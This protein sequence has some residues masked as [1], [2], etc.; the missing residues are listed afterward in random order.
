MGKQ[1]IPGLL[2]GSSTLALG[3]SGGIVG[4]KFRRT[5]AECKIKTKGG[6]RVL[7]KDA[8]RPE[9]DFNYKLFFQMLRPDFWYLIAAVVSALVVAVLNIQIPVYLGDLVQILSESTTSGMS[10][11][12]Y[13][14]Q[15]RQPAVKLLSA[16][17]M[18]AVATCGYISLLSTVG[19]RLAARMREALFASLI[20]QDIAFFDEHGT[21]ELINRLSADVQDFKSAFKLCV[22][23]GLRGTTQAVGSVVSM[24]LLS[25]K[26]TVIMVA[27]VPGIVFGGALIGASLRGLS[28]MVQQQVALAS[29][30]ADEALGNIRTVRAFAM[31]GKEEELY[32]KE[33]EKS[34]TLNEMLGVGIGAFQAISN[35]ALNGIVLGVI[36]SG[37]Y[38]LVT[39]EI[40]AGQLMS[41]LVASQAIQRSLASLSIL[42]GSAVRGMSAG[43]RVF[44]YMCL[45]PSL[46]IHGGISIPYHSLNA[47]V[48]FNGVTFSYPS[49]QEQKVLENFSMSIPKGK[50]M[51]VCGPSGAGKSTVA[52][53]LERFY[54]IQGGSITI[55]GVDIRDLD[56]A[57]LR[58]RCIGFISQ[59]PVLFA[60]SVKEN[61]RYG[62]PDATDQEVM[63]AAALAHAHEFIEDFPNGYNT[64]LGERGVTISGGQKQRIAI[65]R[66]LIKNP[67]VL[68]LDEAT[69]ALDAESE[70]I[71]QETLDYIGRGRTVLVIAH[72]LSTIRNAD[73]IAVLADGQIREIGTH[74]ELVAKKGLYADLIKQQAHE[75][76]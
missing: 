40:Q 22:S 6:S 18:Q 12:E 17:A 68:I 19:E 58:G 54:D 11:S 53:L 46:P 27:T 45:Q 64:V 41:F 57:W 31:E 28:R 71:V 9:P 34:K 48:E 65:A 20:R 51:A 33:I 38:L 3:I 23:Q 66:A 75:H 76:H 42:F 37:G 5:T 59:E 35:L 1:P 14:Q 55:D 50:V 52:T 72:R 16:Y 29:S 24:Y 30:V 32:N 56:P 21:G 39:N 15:I 7:Q 70:R 13:M 10:V 25:P 67:S 36:Y 61:I 26:L 69:S 8:D 62:R 4:L 73:L 49:R 43:A 74:K 44:E 47:N 63:E 2:V 60:T